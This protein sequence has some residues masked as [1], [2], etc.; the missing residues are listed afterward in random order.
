[1]LI[2]KLGIGLFV[3]GLVIEILAVL[4]VHLYLYCCRI[5]DSYQFDEKFD[6]FKRPDIINTPSG[7]WYTHKS[8]NKFHRK[9][10][11]KL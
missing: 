9:W 5:V 10:E 2:L 6:D 7:E 1:M 8:N 4:G 3:I 11:G